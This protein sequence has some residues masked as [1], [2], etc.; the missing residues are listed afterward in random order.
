MKQR[1]S[2]FSLV[3]LSIVLVILGLLTGGI[4]AGQSLIRASELRAV[5]AEYGRYLTSIHSF[6][7]K[8]FAL[9]GDFAQATKFWGRLNSNA[10]CATN[11][12]TAVASPGSCDGNGDGLI[13]ATGAASQSAETYQFWR[14][15]ALAGLIEG[16][17]SGLSGAGSNEHSVLGTN[18]P[19]SKL[20]NAGWSVTYAGLYGDAELYLVDY[21]PYTFEF[22]TAVSTSRT[23]GPALKPEEAWNVDTKTDDGKPA[24]G[25]VIA[26]YWNNQ[27]AAADDGGSANNDLVASYRLSDTAKRCALYFRP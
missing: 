13:V 14:Q 6:R 2:A 19:A 11:S 3:E 18:A 7:D 24:Y 1:D 4:L 10:D 16:T 12:A 26:R 20:S 8:Y 17:Y 22:G 9:P 5:S 21:G 23:F 15:L 27:C 25:K